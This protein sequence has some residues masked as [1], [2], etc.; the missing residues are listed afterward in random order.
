MPA[1]AIQVTGIVVLLVS[2]GAWYVTKDEPTA[3]LAIAGA[4]ILLGGGGE[5]T[6]YEVRRALSR[7]GEP[8]PTDDEPS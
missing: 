8:D 7:R 6:V 4:M 2:L 5:R 3:I 1:W